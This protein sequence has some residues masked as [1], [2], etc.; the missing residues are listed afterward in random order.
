MAETF[1]FKVAGILPQYSKSKSA[2]PIGDDINKI[3]EEFA[4]LLIAQISNQ[5]PDKPA[6]NTDVINQYS[7]M[8]ATLGQVKA[9]KVLEQQAQV[10]VSYDSV[11]RTIVYKTGQ[12]RNPTTN[13]LEDVLERGIVTA[14]DFSLETPRVYVDGRADAVPVADIRGIGMENQIQTAYKGALVVGKTVDY[15]KQIANPAFVDAV[16]TPT[17]P[18]FIQQT[19]SGIVTSVD[20]STGAIPVLSIS[21]EVDPIGLNNVVKIQN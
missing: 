17:E 21:G 3:V 6:E 20:F 9:N 5:D 13:T 7:Q 14:V 2:D 8:L 11:G 15:V 10:Q 16:T 4:K 18:Q 1:D 19:F 12:Q